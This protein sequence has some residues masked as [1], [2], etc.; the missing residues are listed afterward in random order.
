[1]HIRNI[2]RIRHCLDKPSCESLIHAFVTSRLDALNAVLYG[3]P[4]RLL[5]KLQRLQNSAA[6]LLCGIG[7]YEHI[8]PVLKSLHWLPVKQQ[9]IFKVCTLAH[10]CIHGNAPPY[11]CKLLQIYIPHRALRSSDDKFLLTI[12][13]VRTKFG[14]RAFSFNAPMLWNSLPRDV[15]HCECIGTFKKHLKSHLFKIAYD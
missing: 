7:K 10:K 4:E 14:E 1:M 9:I 13:R 2:S 3:I 5:A 8:T 6:R 12:P 15:R 11:L